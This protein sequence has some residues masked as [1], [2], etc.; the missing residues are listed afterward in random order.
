MANFGI[1]PLVRLGRL[2]D[3]LPEPP[4]IGEHQGAAT[5]FEEAGALERLELAR[6]RFAPAADAVTICVTS[7]VALPAAEAAALPATAGPLTTTTRP[8]QA[9]ACASIE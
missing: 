2:L 1:G 8:R 4:G 9:A 7:P 3:Q 6:H 5:A